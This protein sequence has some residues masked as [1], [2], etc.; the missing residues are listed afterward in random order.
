[1]GTDA[2]VE[3]HGM[4]AREFSLMTANGL[5]PAQAL[6][7]GTAKGADLLGISDQTGTLQPGKYADIVAVAGN[8]LLNI[9]ST[10][11]PILV[12]KEGV[13]YMGSK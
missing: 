13:I 10:E 9:K 1:M 7:A 8:P 4:N 3:P 6:L 2:A 5:E 12:M 11:H